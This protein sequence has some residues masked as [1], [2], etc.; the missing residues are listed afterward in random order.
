MMKWLKEV[1]VEDLPINSLNIY[2]IGNPGSYFYNI[3]RSVSS[4]KI[5]IVSSEIELILEKNEFIADSVLGDISYNH[6]EEHVGICLFLYREDYYFLILRRDGG[7]YHRGLV[8]LYKIA[9]VGDLEDIILG[10]EF[11]FNDVE[12][13]N[14]L[15]RELP[16]LYVV[17]RDKRSMERVLLPVDV[18]EVVD[19][20]VSKI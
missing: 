20:K 6:S 2:Q 11:S 5:K 13:E 17:E 18:K 19:Y 4:E 10:R 9:G 8:S 14:R 7:S 3:E 12:E 1:L 15:R 16:L